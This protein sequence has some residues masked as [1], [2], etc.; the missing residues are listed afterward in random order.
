MWKHEIIDAI[1]YMRKLYDSMQHVGVQNCFNDL[2]P[3][4]LEVAKQAQ[5]FYFGDRDDSLIPAVKTLKG[6]QFFFPLKTPYACTIFEYKCDNQDTKGM[7]S[8]QHHSSKRAI[9]VFTSKKRQIFFNLNYSDELKKWELPP[10]YLQAEE[11]GNWLGFHYSFFEPGAHPLITEE[12][13]RRY[14]KELDDEVGACAT[15]IDILNCQNV[16]TKD[17]LPPEKLNHKRMRNGK[18]PLYSY[19]ILEVVKGKPKTKNAGW[20]PWD[21][22]SPE[23]VRFHLCRGHFKTYTEDSKLFGK[24][25]GTF[26]WSPQSR[27]D[28]SKGVIE[29]EYKVTQE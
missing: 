6:K 8:Y 1:N 27:G 29:K 22:K 18:L 21:Y 17:V 4:F 3:F 5:V 7:E 20:V 23:M 12:V 9:V 24:Y 2:Y 26:W 13:V 28:K 14:N 10:V 11:Q 19:K 15:M 25:T 16:V